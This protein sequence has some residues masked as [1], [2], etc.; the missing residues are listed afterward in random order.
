MLDNQ[1][2]NVV[3]PL[4]VESKCRRNFVRFFIFHLRLLLMLTVVADH[5]TNVILKFI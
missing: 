1:Y 3:C 2:M 4:K 5:Y